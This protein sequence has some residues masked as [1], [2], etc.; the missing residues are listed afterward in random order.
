[1]INPSASNSAAN[2]AP[3]ASLSMTASTPVS[4]RGLEGIRE[5]GMPPPPQAMGRMSGDCSR[6]VLIASI[7]MILSECL[8]GYSCAVCSCS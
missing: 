8:C 4:V 7:W 6:M 2:L 5:T 1:M 3:H